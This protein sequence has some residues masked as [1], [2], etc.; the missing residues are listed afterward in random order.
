MCIR[1]SAITGSID[2]TF[3]INNS[4]IRS[5]SPLAILSDDKIL[6]I[7]RY[8][9]IKDSVLFL[10]R[11]ISNGNIDSS[12]NTINITGGLFELKV[13]PDGKIL[14]GG[15]D[16]VVNGKIFGLLA[17]LNFDG[18]IDNNFHIGKYEQTSIN[19]IRD[20]EVQSDG[21]IWIN[22]YFSNYDNT[23]RNNLLRL[24]YD[25]TVDT[26]CQI[27][28]TGFQQIT[29]QKD[30]KLVGI[31]TLS[32]WFNGEPRPGLIRLNPDGNPDTF[33]QKDI[34]DVIA[35]F[36]SASYFS[37]IAILNDGK[38]VVTGS[39]RYG[40]KPNSYRLSLIHISEPTRPY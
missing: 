26:F 7:V 27:T 15:Q 6:G 28:N 34:Q 30:D 22:G 40:S 31:G 25:G 32:N 16:L 3:L 37:D 12:F 14:L 13:Q 33:F 1:D 38:I 24:N 29:L 36:G 10:Q 20:I 21:K 17:R 8:H 18:T 4:S 35:L 2:T 9:Q 19:D 39:I 5:V 23:S 11:L